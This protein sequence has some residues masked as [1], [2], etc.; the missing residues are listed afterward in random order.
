MDG[1]DHLLVALDQIN[2]V[3]HELLPLAVEVLE[4]PPD[5]LAAPMRA[6]ARSL[7]GIRIT[8][9]GPY[10]A[11]IP[12]MSPRLPA[13]MARLVVSRFSFDTGRKY[14]ARVKRGRRPKGKAPVPS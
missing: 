1:S 14:R 7:L 11:M 2:D 3:D 6:R 13:S 9:S 10:S 8:G 12:S 5:R 4:E